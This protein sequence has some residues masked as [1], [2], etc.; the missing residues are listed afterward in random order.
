[1]SLKIQKKKVAILI[2]GNGSNMKA[3]IQDMENP[4]HPG[5]VSL[6]ISDNPNAK[7]LIIAKNFH[8][9]TEII[10]GKNFLHKKKLFERKIKDSIVESETDVICLAGFM[11][12]LS[13]EFIS[14]FEDKILNIHPSILPLFKGLNTHDKALASGM[15]LHGATVHKVTN[16]LDS[17]PILG[18]T[19]IPIFKGDTV[20]SLS[21]RLLYNEKKLYPIIL[22]RFLS[23][24]FDPVLIS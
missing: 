20:Q 18:Q 14:F 15:A 19:I 22:R 1:M 11:K 5:K 9:K 23:N 3:L 24:K 2:S 21:A 12:I 7:G 10:N 17:G 13:S 4:N 6:V 16:E 8:I